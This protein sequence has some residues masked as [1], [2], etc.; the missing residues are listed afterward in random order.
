MANV[1]PRWLRWVIVAICVI[2]AFVFIGLALG[3]Y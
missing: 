3:H 2:A 1:Y